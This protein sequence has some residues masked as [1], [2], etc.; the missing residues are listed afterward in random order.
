MITHNL[1]ML[2]SYKHGSNCVCTGYESPDESQTSPRG[3]GTAEAPPGGL[4]RNFLG[5]LSERFCHGRERVKQRTGHGAG[6][7]NMHRP[8]EY[9]CG[10]RIKVIATTFRS[11]RQTPQLERGLGVYVRDMFAIVTIAAASLPWFFSS[12]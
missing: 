6:D 12:L 2:H 4:R 1:H 3:G 7:S 10:D 8:A 5:E 11:A 9:L